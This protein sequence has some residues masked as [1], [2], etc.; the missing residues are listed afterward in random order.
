M[1]KAFD[2]ATQLTA[3]LIRQFI[4]DGYKVVCRYL[5]PESSW[6][7][8]TAAEAIVSSQT[9]EGLWIVSVFER[10]S[11]NALGGNAQGTEDGALALQFAKEVGQP[12]GS[13]IYFAV[14][15]DATPENYDAIEAYLRAADVQIP[16]YECAVYGE[17]EVCQAMLDRGVV[18]KVWQTYAWSRGLKVDNLNIYQYENDIVVHGIG[19]D[20]NET[21]GDAGGWKLG[22]AIQS[23]LSAEDADLAIGLFQEAYKMGVTKITNPNGVVVNVDQDK[24]HDLANAQRR[25][26]GQ[27][28]Q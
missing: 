15:F 14:D 13:V 27:P 2:C 12:E 5:A 9:D 25:A 1:E 19:V 23:Q 7:R 24:I 20:F 28:E 8:L 26:S 11:D 21:N 17:E 16:G 6:K 10:G 4:A 3:F 18:K 22:M